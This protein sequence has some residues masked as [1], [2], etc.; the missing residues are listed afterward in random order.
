MPFV[1]LASF[2]SVTICT[3]RRVLAHPLPPLLSPAP[4]PTLALSRPSPEFLASS[5]S[6]HLSLRFPSLRPQQQKWTSIPRRASM[7]TCKVLKQNSCSCGSDVSL[8]NR[9]ERHAPPPP[10]KTS[11]SSAFNC[12]LP[13]RSQFLTRVF[14]EP[15]GSSIL[16]ELLVSPGAPGSLVRRC[17]LQIIT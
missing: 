14:L 2:S 6:L 15:L 7:P 11:T 4:P 10:A 17:W 3:S 9:E 13:T 12:Q 16:W 5:S 8:C 1:S